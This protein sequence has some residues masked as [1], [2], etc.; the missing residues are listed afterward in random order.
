[1]NWH[2]SAFVGGAKTTALSIST[3]T[4]RCVYGVGS[5]AQRSALSASF[6]AFSVNRL[7]S[8]NSTLVD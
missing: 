7:D 1:M 8:A 6:G 5:G 2:V 3:C 4:D